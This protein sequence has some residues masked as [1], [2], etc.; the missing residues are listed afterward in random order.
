M[1]YI[2]N[3]FNIFIIINIIIF[4]KFKLNKKLF[5]ENIRKLKGRKKNFKFLMKQQNFKKKYTKNNA[6]FEYFSTQILN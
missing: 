6:T 1:K 2:F 3:K 4:L 5:T